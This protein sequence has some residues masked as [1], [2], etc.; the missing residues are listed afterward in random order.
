MLSNTNVYNAGFESDVTSTTEVENQSSYAVRIVPVFV[1]LDTITVSLNNKMCM[2]IWHKT[3]TVI[4]IY[5]V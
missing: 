1:T 3:K 4:N 5:P 2:F